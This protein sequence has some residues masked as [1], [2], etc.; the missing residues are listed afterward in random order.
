[1]VSDF[2]SFNFRLKSQ[3]LYLI[4]NLYISKYN[5]YCLKI[6]IFF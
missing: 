4:I 1:M 5:H 2:S 3:N 6:S